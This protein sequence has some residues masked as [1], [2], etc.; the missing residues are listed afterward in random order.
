MNI[1]C[2]FS[3]CLLKSL[4]VEIRSRQGAIQAAQ[5]WT[6]GGARC[7]QSATDGRGGYNQT[8]NELRASH[9]P[10]PT[11]IYRFVLEKSVLQKQSGSLRGL[12]KLWRTDTYPIETFRKVHKGEARH[13]AVVYFCNNKCF[14]R[15]LA[16][17]SIL[18]I[19]EQ[20]KAISVCHSVKCIIGRMKIKTVHRNAHDCT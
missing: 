19:T 15:M 13:K 20:N 12:F 5:G 7:L 16:S 10:D 18:L 6:C 11:Q 3:R 8:L 2:S 4:M 1:L 17:H 9:R 14:S